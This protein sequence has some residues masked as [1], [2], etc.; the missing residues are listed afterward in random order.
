[1]ALGGFVVLLIVVVALSRR[2]EVD[3]SDPQVT[4]TLEPL[5]SLDSDAIQGIRVEDL[6][7]QEAIE[8]SR[9]EE[10]LWKLVLPEP[11]E[12]DAARVERAVSWIANP[13]P[14]SEMDLQDD[15]SIFGLVEPEYRV[16]VI[17]E[18]ARQLSFEVGRSAPTGGARYVRTS[19]R[20]GILLMRDFGLQDVLNLITD[21]APTATPGPTEE[22]TVMPSPEGG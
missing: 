19:E 2:G 20:E 1:M 15:L 4:P 5:W 18:D 11:R 10:S 16:T 22:S 9:D 14:R 3:P 12:V 6:L 7:A 17:L 13:V 8:V 21:L